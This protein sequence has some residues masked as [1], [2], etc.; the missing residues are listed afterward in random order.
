MQVQNNSNHGHAAAGKQT[1]ETRTPDW[2]QQ[3]VFAAARPGGT[4][5]PQHARDHDFS[6]NKKR[7]LHDMHEAS[8]G[9]IERQR[10]RSPGLH[11]QLESCED[12]ARKRAALLTHPPHSAAVQHEQES[13]PPPG[14]KRH[15]S[16]AS[17]TASLPPLI[18][19]DE[20]CPA[21]LFDERTNERLMCETSRESLAVVEC[22]WTGS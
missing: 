21:V 16:N 19:G 6:T 14:S 9:N 15:A 18:P 12:A 10:T 20:V 7:S 5:S 2:S 3:T 4:P 13:A 8:A 17:P 11:S 22:R 1:H